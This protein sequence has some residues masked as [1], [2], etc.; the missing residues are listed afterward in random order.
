[1][2]G[3]HRTLSAALSAAVR[4]RWLPGNVAKESR[5][6]RVEA[7][8]VKMFSPDDVARQ[9]RAAKSDPDLSCMLAVLLSVGCRRGEL[10][11][12]GADSLGPDGTLLIHRNV[13]SGDDHRP[14]VKT[15][16]SQSGARCVKL[17]AEV[18]ALLAAQKARVEERALSWGPGYQREPLLLFAAPDGTPMVPSMLTQRLAALKKRAGVTSDASPTHGWRHTSASAMLREWVPIAAVAKRLGHSN[19][20]TTLSIYAHSD[21][22]DDAKAAEMLGA[23]LERSVNVATALPHEPRKPRGAGVTAMARHRPK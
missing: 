9:L 10:L 18:A 11:G 22:S 19:P 6:P 15:P 20:R 4:W 14:I 1:M 23:L 16:K 21:E 13:V 3:A 5:P 8:R 2:H 12:I 7:K 17:P